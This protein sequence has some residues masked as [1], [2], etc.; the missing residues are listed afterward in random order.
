VEGVNRVL[1]L[2]LALL[3]TGALVSSAEAGP[4]P[5][6][7]LIRAV[8]QTRA[9]KSMNI[10]LSERV[11][12]GPQ[13]TTIRLSGVQQL[14]AKRGSFDLD[15]SPAQTGLAHAKEIVQGPNVYIHYGLLGTLHAKDPSVKNWIL[16][17]MNSSLGVDPST[18]APLGVPELREMAGVKVVGSGTDHGV[19]LTRYR[20]TLTLGQAAQ[21]PEVQQLLAH[22]PSAEAA[23]LGGNEQVEFSAG[24][25]GYIHALSSSLTLPFQGGVSLHLAIEATFEDFGRTSAHIPAPPAADVMTLARFDQLAGVAPAADDAAL[26][27]TVVLKP[28]QVGAG[29]TL[30]QIPGGQ[31]VQGETTLDFC[32][33]TYPSESLRSARLQVIYDA[34]G[35]NFSASNEVVTYQPGGAQKALQEV[36]HAAA[37]CPNGRV[38]DPPQGVTDMV[39]HTHVITDRRL[40]SGAVVIVETDTGTV[41]GKQVTVQS[42]DVYQVRGNVLSGVYGSG[43][44]AATVRALTLHAAEQS[45]ENLEHHVAATKS[46]AKPAPAKKK[47][48]PVPSALTA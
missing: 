8:E 37:A 26:L 1:F 32:G 44:E 9:A 29:Y 43:T 30:S 28:S 20:G 36:V 24:T 23:I 40:L 34:K 7:A 4:G 15:I 45:A 22:L 39:R 46:P 5:P 16:V 11:S 31:L 38:K 3:A 35:T 21:S 2:A 6:A 18:L 19:K 27:E 14:Q 47:K 13:A 17:D 25:D 12:V 42:V 33:L 41:K 48:K 10:S